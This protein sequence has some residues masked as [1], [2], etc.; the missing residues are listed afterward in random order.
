MITSPI[1]RY[2]SFHPLRF[3]IIVL[4]AFLLPVLYLTGQW[5]PLP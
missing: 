5:S 4:A 1:L 2:M 3:T